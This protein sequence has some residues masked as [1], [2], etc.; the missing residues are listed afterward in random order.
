MSEKTNATRWDERVA[1]NTIDGLEAL[2]D[3]EMLSTVGG[4]VEALAAMQCAA[5][6]LTAAAAR[7]EAGPSAYEAELIRHCQE[8]NAVA[9]AAQVEAT[10]AEAARDEALARLERAEA[11]LARLG[12]MEAFTNSFALDRSPASAEL[13]ARIDFA[14]AALAS[15]GGE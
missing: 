10:Q 2:A 3:M 13:L 15:K 6:L 4:R 14:Q 11:A 5:R 8:A 12:G 1:Q 7:L 9:E